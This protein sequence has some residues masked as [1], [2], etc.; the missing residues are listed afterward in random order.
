M[1]G[2]A[3]AVIFQTQWF[4]QA[5]FAGFYMAKEKG[6]YDDLGLSV[7][8]LAGGP[9]HSAGNNVVSGIVTF[10]TEWLSSGIQR[11]SKGE[12]VINIAQVVQQS[13]LMLIA[14][15]SKGISIPSD[16]MN[17]KVGLWGG[18]FLIQ[19]MFFFK[20]FKIVP[21]VV[22]LYG[23]TNLFIKGGVD[24]TSAM[25]YNE[26]NMLLN[27][28]FDPEDLTVFHFKDFLPDFPEDGIYCTE[29]TLQNQPE[30]CKSFVIA[31]IKGWHY[32]FQNEN[33]TLDIVLKYADE[34]H[35]QTNR[36]HQKWMLMKMKELILP[37]P[38]TKIG[39]LKPEIYEGA[40]QML[41]DTGLIK[42]IPAY[43]DFYKNLQ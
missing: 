18:D 39:Q 14:R 30:T 5:Q 15:K 16:L 7:K 23:G 36:S 35:Y 29:Q 20:K 41:F 9:E 19:P 11:R 13:G 21:E 38:I 22:E 1:G 4:P 26:F 34:A 2:H 40:A 10:C 37:T 25:Y 28:G 33:E 3:D 31:S 6:F 32:A 43:K 24:A 27:R 8:I 17:K 12:P 42:S